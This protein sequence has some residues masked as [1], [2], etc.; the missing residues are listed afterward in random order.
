MRISCGSALGLAPVLRL[1]FSPAALRKL[2]NTFRYIADTL[3]SPKAATDT[4]AGVLDHLADLKEN[5]DMGPV[6][7]SRINNVP[8]CFADTRFFVCENH[9]A[10][11]EHDDSVIKVL[12][13]YHVRED[14]FGRVFKEID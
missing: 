8:A 11:Y 4:V 3:K 7:S 12:A 2:D 6:L 13:I 5:P 10:V 1:T 14:F 9:I